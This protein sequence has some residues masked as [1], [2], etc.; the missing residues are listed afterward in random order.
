MITDKIINVLLSPVYLLVL[1]LDKVLPDIDFDLPDDVFNGF[2]QFLQTAA[3]ILPV[4][5]LIVWVTFTILLDNF[6]I[7]WAFVLRVKSF[8]PTMGR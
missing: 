2:L 8:I 5:G 6:R 4:K 1:G 7:I 3:Y